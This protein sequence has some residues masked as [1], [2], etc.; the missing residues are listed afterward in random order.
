MRIKKRSAV[1]L[2]LAAAGA[3]AV[4]SIAPAWGGIGACVLVFN[5]LDADSNPA[6]NQP[7]VLLHTRASFAGPFSCANPATNTGGD[8]TVV[9]AGI[10]KA[11]NKPG[12][13]KQLDFN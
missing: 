7:G 12:Y 4:A 1:V 3:L 10:L 2:A 11:A 8:V 6:G 13:G 9:L 5:A